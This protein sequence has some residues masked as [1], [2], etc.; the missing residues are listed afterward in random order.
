MS[1]A[2]EQRHLFHVFST[3]A[4]GGPQVRFAHIA[5]RIGDR[6]RHSVVSISGNFAAREKLP[7][8]LAAD[9]IEPPVNKKLSALNLPTIRRVLRQARPDLLVTYNWGA[10]D[11]ALA[12]AVAPIAPHVHFE[13]GFG[14]E[15]AERQLRRRVLYRRLALRRTRQLIVPSL[16][17]QR[18]ATEIW[19]QPQNR[20]HYVPNGIDVDRF[21]GGGDASLLPAAE[22]PVIG[23]VAALRPEKNLGRLLR[24]FAVVH[25][26]LPL[27]RLAI[28]GDGRVRGELERQAAGMGLGDAVIFTGHIAEPARVVPLFDIFALSSDTEQMPLSVL[29][30]MAAAKP[31]ASVDVGDVRSMVADANQRFVVPRDDEAA[32]AQA[33]LVLAGDAAL[34]ASLGAANREAA[35]TRFPPDRMFETYER[36]LLG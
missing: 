8:G 4:V 1:D 9:F 19:R 12:N 26:S 31:V 32:F 2:P 25:A 33:M 21:T 30:A 11:W 17:L 16:T 20:V 27:S 18:I 23:T 5:E 22:G 24:A 34:R 13:D 10:V 28:V 7:A 6:A 15:E 36:L 14:P 29:E 35:R 3:F